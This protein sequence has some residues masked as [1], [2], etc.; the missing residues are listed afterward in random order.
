MRKILI[1]SFLI[2]YCFLATGQHTATELR[3]SFLNS[4]GDVMV[5][6][7]R[8]VH[9][10][11]PENS[12]A[13]IEE[14][15]RLHV[16]IVEIDVKVSKDGIPFL[17]HDRT[18]D[19]TTNGKGDPENYSWEEL[20]LLNI[21]DNGKITSLKI[22]SLE[23]AL[24][25]SRGKILVDLDLKTDRIKDVISVVEKTNMQQ[26][27]IF[28]ESDYNI[29]SSVKKSNNKYFIMPRIHS[30]QEADS[31]ISL[32]DPPVIHLDFGCYTDESVAL[33][34]GS[35]A[36]IWI[37]SLGEPDEEIRNGAAK[38]S[39]KKLLSK[40]ANIIQTDEPAL[41]LEALEK[42]GYRPEL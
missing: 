25:V 6:A 15:I 12:L 11:F 14:A 40:G 17:M 10:K 3:K 5:A 2:L 22:P 28:F 16:D 24:I 20:Q 34:K 33:I 39:L 8:G 36:R 26:E 18:M 27:V 23:E 30:I 37:N 38:R 1:S 29:L 41:L 13:A 35:F 32:F 19:R 31:A 9:D 4:S 21:V 7:H 42:N